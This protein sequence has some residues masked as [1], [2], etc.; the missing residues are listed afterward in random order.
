MG[1]STKS[2]FYATR[3]FKTWVISVLYNILQLLAVFVYF[4]SPPSQCSAISLHKQARQVNICFSVIP[5]LSVCP[6]WV[7]FSNPSFALRNIKMST[8]PNYKGPHLFLFSLKHSS[9]FTCAGHNILRICRTTS[10]LY[11]LFSCEETAQHLQPYSGINI[12]QKFSILYFL[13]IFSWFFV[14]ARRL[15]VFKYNCL[16]PCY[17][18]S[19]SKQ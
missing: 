19:I 6:V 4:N 9:L 14:A 15:L 18:Y 17:V 16:C 5:L 1:K 7:N 2:L 12:T 11:Q 3:S 8:D 10:L 13:T